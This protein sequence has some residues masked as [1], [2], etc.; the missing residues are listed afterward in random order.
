MLAA[1]SIYDD[2]QP[3]LLASAICQNL[4]LGSESRAVVMVPL[5][6]ATTLRLLEAFKQAMLD[7]DTPLFCD[8]EDELVGQDDW[9]GNEDGGQVKCWLGIFSRGGSPMTETTDDAY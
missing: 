2:D 4:A 6:D 5:R 9:I 8:E 7:L 1:D 3:I